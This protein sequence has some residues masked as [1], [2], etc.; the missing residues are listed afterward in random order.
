MLVIGKVKFTFK[1]L[2]S[3]QG[4][5]YSWILGSDTGLDL[6][7][8]NVSFLIFCLLELTIVENNFK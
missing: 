2:I 7:Q 4:C 5:A 6:F 8:N 3:P 1:V